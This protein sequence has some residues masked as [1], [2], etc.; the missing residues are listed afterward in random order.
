MPIVGYG[1][2]IIGLYGVAERRDREN[3]CAYEI[4]TVCT[5]PGNQHDLA[6]DYSN[7]KPTAVGHD[8]ADA[9]A[10]CNANAR[11]D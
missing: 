9:H 8:Y 5:D 4:R 2:G 3:A 1:P 7:T 10:N 11:A 6:P